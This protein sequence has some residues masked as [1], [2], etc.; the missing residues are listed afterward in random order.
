MKDQSSD[1]EAAEKELAK[2]RTQITR[3]VDAIAE[4]DDASKHE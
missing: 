4:G 3:I 1:R 2:I